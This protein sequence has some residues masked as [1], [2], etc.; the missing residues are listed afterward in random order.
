MKDCNVFQAKLQQLNNLVKLYLPLPIL[1]IVK[2]MP[3]CNDALLVGSTSNGKVNIL[4]TFLVL[5]IFGYYF[6]SK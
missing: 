1:N 2:E 4:L 6:T 3:L 5:F